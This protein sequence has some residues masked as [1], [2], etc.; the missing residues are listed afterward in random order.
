MI[1]QDVYCSQCGK[2]IPIETG[3]ETEE[4]ICESCKKNAAS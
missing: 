1:I 2:R 4:V 3:I